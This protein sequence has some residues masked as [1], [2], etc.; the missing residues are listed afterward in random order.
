MDGQL[1][2][3]GLW[4]SVWSLGEKLRQDAPEGMIIAVDIESV[5]GDRYRPIVLQERP[6]WVVIEVLVS[7]TRAEDDREIVFVREDHITKIRIFREAAA[8]QPLGFASAR[9]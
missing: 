3:G 4:H 1:V 6:P 9:S 8:K 2:D 5:G 7:P